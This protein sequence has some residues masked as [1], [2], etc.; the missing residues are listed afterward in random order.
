ML[1]KLLCALAATA[2]G[3]CLVADSNLAHGQVVTGEVRVLLMVVDANQPVPRSLRHYENG[4]ATNV[5]WTDAST[6]QHF[7]FEG[8][9]SFARLFEEMSYGE[10]TVSGDTLLM[11][12]PYDASSRTWRQWTSLADAEAQSRGFDLSDYDRFLYILPYRPSNARTAGLSQ[13]NV[14]W[15]V[16]YSYVE[17][18][19]LFHELGHMVGLDHAAELLADG[20]TNGTAPPVLTVVGAPNATFVTSTVSML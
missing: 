5:A 8:E 2:L 3:L 16:P 12:F 7:A 9:S 1:R 18:S 11:A 13:G 14:G 17:L 20:S 4:G 15:C 6:I 19:C 10:L